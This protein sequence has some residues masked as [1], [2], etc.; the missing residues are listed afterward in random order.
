MLV[1]EG[2]VTPGVASRPRVLGEVQG[3]VVRVCEGDLCWHPEGQGTHHVVH[4][5]LV[6]ASAQYA[7]ALAERGVHVRQRNPHPK[8]RA[9]PLAQPATVLARAVPHDA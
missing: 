5:P 1:E 8:Q 9:A 7:R 6:L 3:E 2:L 4:D